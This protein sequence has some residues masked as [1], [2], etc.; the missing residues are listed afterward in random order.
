MRRSL[1]TLATTLQLA[2]PSE[3][4]RLVDAR[5]AACTASATARARRGSGSTL[6][7]SRYPSSIPTCSTIGTTSRTVRQTAAE[8]S[9]YSDM[10]GGTK[11]TCG[12]RRSA[13]ALDIAE[14]MP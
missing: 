5:T 7:R 14:R 9:E 10:W 6:P 8:Y 11:T 1:A 13:S 12:Q 3:Q 4:E 2:T